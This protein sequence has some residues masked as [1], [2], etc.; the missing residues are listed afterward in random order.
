MA[1]VNIVHY[2]KFKAV[3]ENGTPLSGGK[4]YT[5]AAGGSTP[6]TTYSDSALSSAN[7]NPVVL[8]SSGEADIYC[9]N[10]LKIVLKTS[11]DVTV[12]TK[13]NI[14]P[15]IAP[16]SLYSDTRFKFGSTTHDISVNG[17]QAVTGLG[18]T[19]TGVIL[20]SLINLDSPMSI[21]WGIPASQMV[22]ADKHES[23]ANTWEW[24]DGNVIFMNLASTYTLATLTSLDAD[25]F[26]ITWTK[27]GSPTGTAKIF[28]LALR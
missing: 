9:A 22:V 6:E 4:V 11:L 15:P 2:P 17:A 8:D 5:Y 20:L 18:F 13:D 12:W 25:G 7:A 19:P 28:Y 26:T 21:G 1:S 10:E 3:D 27:N 14:Q 23:D 16:S 24:S